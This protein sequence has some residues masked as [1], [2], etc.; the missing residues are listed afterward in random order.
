MSGEGNFVAGQ[1]RLEV[2]LFTLGGVCLLP[3]AR[4][5]SPWGCP[6]PRTCRGQPLGNNLPAA[7]ASIRMD[8]SEYWWPTSHK[9]TARKAPFT[10][11]NDVAKTLKIEH[12][13]N[14]V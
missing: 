1:A 9:L 2:P 4:L 14:P 11:K 7:F 3:K 8:P 12:S 6:R 5:R 10:S 13:C